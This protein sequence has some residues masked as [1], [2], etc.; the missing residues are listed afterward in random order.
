MLHT[1]PQS[2]EKKFFLDNKKIS[3][4]LCGIQLQSHCNK[5]T[6]Q[7]DRRTFCLTEENSSYQLFKE[8]IQSPIT[9][10]SDPR[11]SQLGNPAKSCLR[12]EKFLPKYS[13][14]IK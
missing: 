9:D 5:D 7:G 11:S 4:L 3:K 8:A 6:H 12:G 2:K 13:P 1:L 14:E 10:K